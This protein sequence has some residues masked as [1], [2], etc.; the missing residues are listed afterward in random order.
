[1][2]IG[3]NCL[4]FS[5]FTVWLSYLNLSALRVYFNI[6]YPIDV[7]FFFLLSFLHSAHFGFLLLTKCVSLLL[8]HLAFD[9]FYVS[10]FVLDKSGL[11]SFSYDIIVIKCRSLF[12]HD[13]TSMDRASCLLLVYGFI[14]ILIFSSVLLTDHTCI[15]L[16]S[17]LL[18]VYF[19][20]LS[21]FCS[22][23]SSAVLLTVKSIYWPISFLSFSF[24]FGQY[25]VV[26]FGSTSTHR[27]V[28]RNP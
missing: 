6:L 18:L 8:P 7:S 19:F 24:I 20:A 2:N 27:G 9:W 12:F 25:F 15:D 28:R 17:C 16:A 21:F 22:F 5:F 13:H 14:L 3:V 23:S 11:T 4:A 1:M 26:N 10:C